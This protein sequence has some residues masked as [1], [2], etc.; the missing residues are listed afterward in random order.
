MTGSLRIVGLGAGAPGWLTPEAAAALAEASDLVGYKSYVDRVAPEPGQ[1]RHVSDNREEASRAICALRLAAA[2]RRV[3]VVSSGDPGVFAMAAA[4]FEAIE[5]GAPEWRA[6]DIAVLPGITAVLA[7]AA[8]V[9]APLGSDFCVLNLS[10]NLKPWALIARRLR[11]AA[12]ADFVIALYNPASLARP[13]QIHEAFAILRATRSGQ[14]PVVFA[15]AIG[16][17]GEKIV[18]SSLAEADP[19]IADMRT[20]VIIGASS[21][22]LIPRA[23]G[24]VWVYSPR[25][26]EA[27]S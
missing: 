15:A 19:A 24:G 1:A 25:R 18:V 2:G 14:T 22:R 21:T 3:A 8:R 9:G 4:I 5:A 10:D 13:R 6:L 11:L 23:D 12:E 17:R 16:Q 7:A 27:R 20:L 26:A